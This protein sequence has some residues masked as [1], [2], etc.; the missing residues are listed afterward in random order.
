MSD[1]KHDLE[2]CSL[3]P[4]A[5]AMSGKWK[6]YII[7]YLHLALPNPCRYGELKRHIPYNISHKVFSQQLQELERDKIVAR[8]E[9]DEKIPRVEY[10]LT[11]QG[12]FLAPVILYL[13]DWSAAFNEQFGYDALVERT[14]GKIDGN[15]ITYGYESKELNK[16]VKIEFG[17]R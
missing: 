12:K 13:R 11:E 17:F 5:V 16:H 8:T 4:A 6:F 3:Y 10:S 2:S 15:S 7:W 9:Y 1:H 14:Q